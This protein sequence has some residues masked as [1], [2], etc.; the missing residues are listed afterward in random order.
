MVNR[1]EGRERDSVGGKRVQC[2]WLSSVPMVFLY[3]FV[4][5]MIIQNLYQNLQRKISIPLEVELV[6]GIN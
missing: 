5:E 3:S 4:S 6:S 1:V 2:G